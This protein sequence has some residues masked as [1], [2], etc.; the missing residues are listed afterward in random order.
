[1]RV[2][3]YLR[4]GLLSLAIVLRGVIA[5]ARPKETII[6]AAREGD[7]PSNV[8]LSALHY[9]LLANYMPNPLLAIAGR[10]RHS[11]GMESDHPYR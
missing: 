7:L 3:D 1:M 2:H 10:Q 8:H 11:A 5:A 9:C 6:S 4:V